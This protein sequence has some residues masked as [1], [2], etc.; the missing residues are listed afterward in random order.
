MVIGTVI[1][2]SFAFT[3]GTGAAAFTCASAGSTSALAFTLASV[4]AIGGGLTELQQDGCRV[5]DG[6]G[7]TQSRQGLP[8][9]LVDF[10]TIIVAHS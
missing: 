5:G 9:P 4:L 3:W 2:L 8:T 1:R 7:E 6:Q 10:T